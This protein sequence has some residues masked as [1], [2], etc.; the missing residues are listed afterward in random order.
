MTPNEIRRRSEQL[1][2]RGQLADAGR[3]VEDALRLQPFD[4]ELNI[5][6]ANV[7][8]AG[9]QYRQAMETLEAILERRPENTDA[10]FLLGN[11]CRATSLHARAVACY[12]EVAR[13]AP[14][15]P[16]VD[17]FLGIAC[18][19]MG[20][21]PEAEQCFVRAVQRRPDLARLHF[22]LGTVRHLQDRHAE[23]VTSYQEVLRREP[24][25]QQALTNLSLAL[26]ALGRDQQA[27]EVAAR[28]VAA[29]PGNAMA[30][31]NRLYA[32]IALGDQQTVAELLD[33]RLIVDATA[34]D[35]NLVQSAA[36]TVRA[37]APKA[38]RN[39][40][41]PTTWRTGYLDLD[42]HPGLQSLLMREIEALL[43]I[44]QAHR[45]HPWAKA[46]PD[47]WELRAW[48]KALGPGGV[49]GPHCQPHAWAAGLLFL[50]VPPG[51][52]THLELGRGDDSYRDL[53]PAECIRFAARSGRC[54][55]FP[56]Y[57]FQRLE[58]IQSPGQ[59]LSIG[60]EVVVR[61]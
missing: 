46:A 11:A 8:L 55:V 20:R 19:H 36:E 59:T 56:A 42:A 38:P 22:R 34:T 21:L 50:D 6:K 2:A 29:R 47:R 1:V 58:P 30:L 40:P 3:M 26:L 32:A 28:H 7:M 13:R 25:H 48:G 31:A 52:P 12:Q 61:P 4:T 43:Q 57:F 41:P 15:Y 14:D 5:A 37:S 44:A 35:D 54:I 24:D 39:G 53:A 10:L 23:A 49:D 51:E 9:R 17:H 45:R 33:P 18:Q 16:G 60:F 27:A